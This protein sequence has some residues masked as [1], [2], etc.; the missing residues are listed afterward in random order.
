[1]AR[2]CVCVCVSFGRFLIQSYV[3]VVHIYTLSKLIGGP[4]RLTHII[5]GSMKA[6][7][8]DEI[9][10]EI[11]LQHF[12]ELIKKEREEGHIHYEGEDS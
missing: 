4:F 10:I 3:C 1:M 2:V 11:A 8:Y 5:S 12:F 7:K 9:E 6:G